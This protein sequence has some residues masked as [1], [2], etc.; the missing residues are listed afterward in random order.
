MNA[1][2]PNP[3][4]LLL[5]TTAVFASMLLGHIRC[6]NAAEPFPGET[7]PRRIPLRP[8]AR[9]PERLA[10]AVAAVNTNQADV[11]VFA[12]GDFDLR[13]PLEFTKRFGHSGLR[14]RGAG[15]GITRLRCHAVDVGIRVS[16]DTDI[17]QPAGNP[18]FAVEDLSLI[19]KGECGTAIELLRGNSDKSGGTAPKI[20]RRLVIEGQDGR[21]TNGIKAT[22]L[23]F[24]TF[25]D[26]TFRLPRENSTGIHL[27][28][29][30]SPVDH[31]LTGLRFLGGG[32]GIRVSGTVEGVYLTQITMIG[33]DIGIDWDTAGHEPLLSLSGSHINARTCC[34]RADRLLQP[35]ITGNLFYQA[36]PGK[37]W[38]GIEIRTK[39]ATAYDLFQISSNT[40]HGHPRHEAAST[41]LFIQ[42]AGAG[43]VH[44][45]IFSAVDT[46]I[47]L[48]QKA[49]ELSVSGSLFRNV[50]TNIKRPGDMK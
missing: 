10:A 27:T 41:G 29:E 7:A 32:T 44:G 13:E 18:S 20:F 1:T 49:N 22:D 47:Q 28:G 50:R 31:H 19:A 37:T 2:R 33:T 5:L 14:I 16:L 11:L 48:G 35:I 9:F 25:R 40:F 36:D 6:P 45:N 43:V 21:W 38:T 24:C 46:G 23:T 15:P 26:L 39:R 30:T 12:P 42:A 17:R 3:A 4:R 34:V 8:G